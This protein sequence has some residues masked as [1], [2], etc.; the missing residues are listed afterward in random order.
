MI[1][2]N[3]PNTNINTVAPS[4]IISNAILSLRLARGRHES[5][6]QNNQHL[7]PRRPR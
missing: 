7:Q 5:A 6:Y 4:A 2:P 1:P 3:T